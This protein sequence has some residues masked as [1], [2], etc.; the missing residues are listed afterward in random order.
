MRDPARIPLFAPLEAGAQGA[1]DGVRD[2]A[3]QPIEGEPRTVRDDLD[4]ALA[5]RS[6]RRSH[7]LGC[8]DSGECVTAT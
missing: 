6:A 3:N 7:F 8:L 4:A 1:L 5:L 2:M